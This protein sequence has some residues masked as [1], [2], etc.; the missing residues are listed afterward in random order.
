MA[1][2]SSWQLRPYMLPH[3]A[4]FG[5]RGTADSVRVSIQQTKRLFAHVEMSSFTVIVQGGPAQPRTLGT[6]E[7]VCK[8]PE[9]SRSREADHD[10]SSK[11]LAPVT[12]DQLQDA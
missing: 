7:R 6:F 10:I 11:S 12:T 1:S 8:Q 9:H 4:D 2:S 3:R 5:L